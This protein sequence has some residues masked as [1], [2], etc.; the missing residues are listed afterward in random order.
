[1]PLLKAEVNSNNFPLLAEFARGYLHQDLVPE[2]GSPLKAAEAYLRDI[3]VTE[4]ARLAVEARKFRSLTRG[5]DDANAAMQKLGSV[6]IFRNKSELEQ[7]LQR[8][9]RA[10]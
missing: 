7:L 5:G 6:W 1:V 3:S 10:I 8:F 9:E 2:H 4:H